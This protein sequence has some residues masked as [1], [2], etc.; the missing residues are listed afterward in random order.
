MEPSQDYPSITE[1]LNVDLDIYA[2]FDLQPLVSSLGKKVMVLYVGRERRSYT[3][4]LELAGRAK[5]A[6]STIRGLCALIRALPRAEQQLWNRA[7]RRDFSIGVQAGQQ[8]NSSDFAVETATVQAVAQLGAR[9][10]ITVYSPR[11]LS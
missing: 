3:A 1:F 6:D 7:K 11:L 8:P 9:I 4:H 5:S 10:V 2:P